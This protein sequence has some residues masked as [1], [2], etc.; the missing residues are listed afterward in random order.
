MTSPQWD[1]E[2]LSRPWA[3]AEGAVHKQTPERR[4]LRDQ[5]GCGLERS[6]SR[7]SNLAFEG[8]FL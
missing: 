8:A 1:E 6:S 7:M 5:A 3:T 2:H 4:L